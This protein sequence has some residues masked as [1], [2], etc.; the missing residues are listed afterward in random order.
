[1]G[2]GIG[3]G[4]TVYAR[5]KAASETED[6]HCRVKKAR[7]LVHTLTLSVGPIYEIVSITWEW[8]WEKG[9]QCM[10]DVRLLVRQKTVTVE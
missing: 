3:G 7:T 9:S 5:R 10:R 6:S 1:M 2:V 4:L 8:V